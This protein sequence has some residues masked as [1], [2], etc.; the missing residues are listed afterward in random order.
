MELL[1]V[2][3]RV[4]WEKIKNTQFCCLNA[5]EVMQAHLGETALHGNNDPLHVA[6]VTRD[7]SLESAFADATCLERYGYKKINRYK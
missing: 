7:K 6:R 5:V 4:L 1:V 3:L 2:L